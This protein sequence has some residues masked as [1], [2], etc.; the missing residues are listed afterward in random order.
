MRQTH[1]AGW[2]VHKCKLIDAYQFLNAEKASTALYW[3]SYTILLLLLK[4]PEIYRKKYNLAWGWS[5]YKTLAKNNN[6]F[7]FKRYDLAVLFFNCTF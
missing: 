5:Q 4:G 7:Y 6:F 3:S 1:A 2:K